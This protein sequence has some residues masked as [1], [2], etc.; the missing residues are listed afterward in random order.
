MRVIEQPHDLNAA[1]FDF[2]DARFQ[3]S[4]GETRDGGFGSHAKPRVYIVYNSTSHAII[5]LPPTLD[6]LES[7]LQSIAGG[8]RISPNFTRRTE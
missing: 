4:L 1:A 5:Q 2:E 6:G 8:A 7:V 3:Q